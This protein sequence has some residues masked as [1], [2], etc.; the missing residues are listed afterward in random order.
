MPKITFIGGPDKEVVVEALQALTHR[1][2]VLLGEASREVD[3]R[4][5]WHLQTTCKMPS[6]LIIVTPTPP[7][8]WP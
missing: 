1:T 4:L 6:D 7:L 8:R 2:L 5:N 3:E